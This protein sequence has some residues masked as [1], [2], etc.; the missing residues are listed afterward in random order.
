M[1][2]APLAPS[3][4]INIR[5]EV[6]SCIINILSVKLAVGSP[7]VSA[8]RCIDKWQARWLNNHWSLG[9]NC[10]GYIGVHRDREFGT[11]NEL[12]LLS[13]VLGDVHAST[14]CTHRELFV[15]QFVFSLAPYAIRMRNSP[16][17]SKYSEPQG[18]VFDFLTLGHFLLTF[19]L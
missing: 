9:K 15:K 7:N 13:D 5:W 4:T 2:C 3:T 10:Q 18:G 6:S 8:N 19:W 12:H 16:L 11:P 17:C 1:S 14:Q